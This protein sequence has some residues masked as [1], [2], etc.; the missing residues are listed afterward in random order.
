MCDAPKAYESLVTG[1]ALGKATVNIGERGVGTLFE[2]DVI[3]FGQ[4]VSLFLPH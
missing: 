4:F 1:R 3:A 2:Q